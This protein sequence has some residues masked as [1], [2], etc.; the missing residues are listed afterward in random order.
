MSEICIHKADKRAGQP[1]Q[2]E[3]FGVCDGMIAPR[4]SLLIVP[5]K[6]TAKEWEQRKKII[7]EYFKE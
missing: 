6:E 2:P 5:K 1:K 3:Q 7:E 4:G